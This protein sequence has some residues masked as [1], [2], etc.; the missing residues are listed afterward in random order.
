M[1][2]PLEQ[3]D[4]HP[5][6]PLDEDRWFAEPLPTERAALPP[7]PARWP[8]PLAALVACVV[9]GSGLSLAWR[10]PAGVSPPRV[11]TLEPISAAAPALAPL[12]R[13]APAKQRRTHATA[14]SRRT[15]PP[16]RADRPAARPVR[17]GTYDLV[18]PFPE[19]P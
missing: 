7:S 8:R 9:L 17:S 11:E 4:A 15:P 2:T 16:A 1:T 6:P 19:D 5:V 14:V 18:D 12:P 10:R 3:T 13:L